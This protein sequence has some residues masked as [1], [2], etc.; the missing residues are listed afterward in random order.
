M[1]GRAVRP[2]DPSWFPSS[3]DVSAP[4]PGASSPDPDAGWSTIPEGERNMRMASILGGIWRQGISAS[5]FGAL[6]L[7]LNKALCQPPLPADEIGVLVRSISRYEQE[8]D[9]AY[10]IE[11]PELD[12]QLDEQADDGDGDALWVIGNNFGPPPPKTWFWFPFIPDANMTMVSGREGIGKGLFCV[13]LATC[14][15]LGVHPDTGEKIEPKNVAWLTAEDDPHDDIWPRLRAAGW[16]PA[17]HGKVHFLNRKIV[18]KLPEDSAPFERAL[19]RIPDLGL[20][21][22]DPGRSYFGRKDG[23][24]ISYNDE[25]DVRPA[26]V[27]LQG[28]AKAMRVPMI[29]VSHWRKGEG[30]TRDM[31]SGSG[32]WR[33]VCRHVLDFAEAPADDTQKAFWVGKTNIDRKGYVTGYTTEG[34]PEFQ[35]AKW[36]RGDDLSAEYHSLDSWMDSV[37]AEEYALTDEDMVLPHLTKL[38]AGVAIPDRET[39]CE[40]TGLSDGRMRKVLDS[41]KAQGRLTPHRGLR[42]TWNG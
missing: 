23:G 11:E 15:M 29:F 9:E 6:A 2:F 19:E 20:V 33:Q 21:I 26:M 18:L 41:L 16:D 14:M 42:S 31:T 38:A 7:A 22:M 40:L 4:G 25:A 5:K 28:I 12:E 17:V 24:Q 34:V 10:V 27:E 37:K 3:Q 36:V 35:T 32:A 30:H 13:Y 1:G 8:P 39:L